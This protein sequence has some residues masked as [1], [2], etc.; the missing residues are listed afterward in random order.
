M[1]FFRRWIAAVRRWWDRR[2]GRYGVVFVES[3]EL[4]EVL[5]DK[6]IVIAREDGTLWSA[7]MLCPCGCGDRLELMLLTDVR[8]R[9]DVHFSVDG[10]PSLLPSVWRKQACRSHFWLRE[11]RIQWCR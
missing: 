8:P 5:P 1:S 11:G 6:T 7:G 3:D 4:P 10:R 9:W 2:R